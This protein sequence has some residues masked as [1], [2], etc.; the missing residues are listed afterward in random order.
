[1]PEPAATATH[2]QVQEKTECRFCGGHNLQTVWSFATTPPANSYLLPEEI[3]KKEV[4]APLVVARCEDC[5]LVQLKHVVDPKVLFANYLYVSSTSPSFVAHFEEYATHL[6]DR[7]SLNK[8]SLVVDVGSNDGVLLKP[9][10]QKG[11]KVLGIEPA[12]NIAEQANKEGIETIAQFFGPTLAREIKAEKG[13]AT[14]ITANNVFAHTDD[15]PFF[16]EA[17][18]E[19]LAPDGIFVFEVQYLKDLIE[20]NLFDIVYHEHLYYYHITPLR[21]F[22]EKM[23]M[24]IFDVEHVPVHGGSLRVFV[25]KK[26]GSHTISPTVEQMINAETALNTP[27]PYTAFAERITQNKK[28]LTSMLHALKEADNSIVGF[29]APAK[30]TTLLYTF[31]IDANILEFI[32]DDSAF[33]QGRVMPGS[34]I[35]IVGPEAL[36]KEN[37]DYCLILA[38]NFAEPIMKNHGR[39]T[40]QGGKFIIPVPTPRIV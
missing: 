13:P 16:V 39:F 31:G 22:F 8:D 5:F 9:L 7:F 34:H 30:A 25:Q 32:V 20:K 29:G 1:M 12:K 11:V 26:G 17:V 19:L 40:K 14:I 10:Q 28:A 36:Y 6:I 24:E 23:G 18:K 3:G 35:P 15:I 27:A 38:W 2:V 37:P 33:K 4:M 21:Q